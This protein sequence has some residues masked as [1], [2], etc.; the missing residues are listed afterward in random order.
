MGRDVRGTRAIAFAGA[1]LIALIAPLSLQASEP[2][3][4]T[5]VGLGAAVRAPQVASTATVPRFVPAAIAT[6]GRSKAARATA[7][8]TSSVT[9]GDFFY[10][11]ETVTIDQGDT[12]T[13]T[14]EG[15]VPEGHTVT[16]DGFDS[17]VIEEGGTFSHQFVEAGTFDYICALHDNMTGTVAVRAP[18]GEVPTDPGAGGGGTGGGGTGGSGGG[19]GA[20]E[21]GDGGGGQGDGGGGGGTGGASG[22]GGGAGT[23][24]GSGSGSTADDGGLDGPLAS[25]GANLILLF[26]IGIGLLATGALVRRLNRA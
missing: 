24:G 2:A 10:D 17:G 1:A 26:E 11:P 25:T 15:T 14:N 20:G 16:G 6:R 9:I 12:V 22:S 23:S 3:G 18:G 8:A 21:G 5:S 4:G 13:W 19:G 7:S